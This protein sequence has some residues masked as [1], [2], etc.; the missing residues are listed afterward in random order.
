MRK[1]SCVPSCRW[2][3]SSFS[4]NQSPWLLSFFSL[5]SSGVQ[6]NDFQEPS[7]LYLIFTHKISDGNPDQNGKD[8]DGKGYLETVD[9][10]TVLIPFVEKLLVMLQ[11][12]LTCGR[13]LKS[14]DEHGKH[15]IDKKE[16]KQDQDDNGD[17]FPDIRAKT[18][19]FLTS[20]TRN[21]SFDLKRKC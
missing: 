11:R 2:R 7:A 13:I 20:P 5:H 18:F 10:R 19:H 16:N 14:L 21:L 1:T 17:K 6:N 4:A 8:R 15:G 9:Q 3:I 12:P